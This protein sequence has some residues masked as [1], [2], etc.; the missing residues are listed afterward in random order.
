MPEDI[1]LPELS[2]PSLFLILFELSLEI[3]FKISLLKSVKAFCNNLITESCISVNISSNELVT[4]LIIS[5]A[6]DSIID[7]VVETNSANE[8]VTISIIS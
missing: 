4:T 7:F 3:L 8:L 5:V 6:I 1:V 2:P